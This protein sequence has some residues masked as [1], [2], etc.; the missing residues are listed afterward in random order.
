[1][2]LRSFLALSV[3]IGSSF[4][5][6][7]TLKDTCLYE[8]GEC[9]CVCVSSSM[10]LG[11]VI[12]VSDASW[13]S[14]LS[15]SITLL[16]SGDP[17]NDLFLFCSS[18]SV[19]RGYS[20]YSCESCSRL[21]FGYTFCVCIGIGIGTKSYRLGEMDPARGIWRMGL[22]CGS[23]PSRSYSTSYMVYICAAV[24]NW[25]RVRIGGTKESGLNWKILEAGSSFLLVIVRF[26][27]FIVVSICKGNACLWTV[28]YISDTCDGLFTSFAWEDTCVINF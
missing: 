25:A 18:Y 19:D 5:I 22:S 20:S 11:R 21:R 9:S 23:I 16:F 10:S 4:F 15:G 1:M 7:T 13:S 14:L 17:G 2:I 26:Y 27:S 6:C 28:G 12:I 8:S 3:L 24:A